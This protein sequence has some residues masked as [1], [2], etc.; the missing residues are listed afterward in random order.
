LG[1]AGAA[2]NLTPGLTFLLAA[3]YMILFVVPSSVKTFR[4]KRPKKGQVVG[5]KLRWKL[6]GR[7]AAAAALAG[8]CF[9]I[10]GGVAEPG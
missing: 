3:I 5:M 6:N 1:G 7:S 9:C 10:S 4:T 8:V 2:L